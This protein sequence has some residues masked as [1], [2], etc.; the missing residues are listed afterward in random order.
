MA[1]PPKKNNPPRRTLTVRLPVT[2]IERLRKVARDSAGFP[3]YASMSGIVEAGIT[4]ECDRLD[5]VLHEAF[6]DKPQSAAARRDLNNRR[7]Q[8]IDCADRR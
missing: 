7:V 3:A 2:L 1:G 5:A 8:Q 4:T 6:R